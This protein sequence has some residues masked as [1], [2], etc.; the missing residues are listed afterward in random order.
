[1][2]STK[3]ADTDDGPTVESRQ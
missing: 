1:L 3:V 2:D